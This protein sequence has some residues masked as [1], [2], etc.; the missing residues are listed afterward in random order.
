MRSTILVF[1]LVLISCGAHA[2]NCTPQERADAN[3]QLEAIESNEGTRS[4]ILT[5]HLPFGVHRSTQ[6]LTPMSTLDLVVS[7]LYC[8]HITDNLTCNNDADAASR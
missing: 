2:R 8:R 6:A 4:S 3:A 1:I 5:Q 7:Y